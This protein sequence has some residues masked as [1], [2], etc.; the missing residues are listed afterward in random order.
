MN[1]QLLQSA[2]QASQ[3]GNHAETARICQEIRRSD[4]LNFLALF[5]EGFAHS[6]LGG[7]EEAERLMDE[8][9]K[10]NPQSAEAIYNRGCMLR[11]LGRHAEAL[12]CFERALTLK[13]DFLDAQINRGIA[14]LMVK[15]HGEA[16]AV[17]DKV[18]KSAPNEAEGWNNR[19][20]ALIELQRLEEALASL[21]RAISLRPDYDR[22]W[23]NRGITLYR[24]KRY[25]ESLVSL[26]RALAVNPH[27][28]AAINNRGN[29]LMA[30]KRFEEAA[31]AF[32]RAS[33]PLRGVGGA[34]TGD[35]GSID[36]LI[37]YGTALLT[38][39]RP[40]EAIAMYT[41]ALERQ[42]A[43]TEALC[44]RANA[45]VTQK[46]YEE[47]VKDCDAILKLEPEFK[48]MRGIAAHCRL[49]CCDWSELENDRAEIA[50]GLKAGKR[51]VPPLEIAAIASTAKEQSMAAR[52]VSADKHPPSAN[53]LWRGEIY[54]HKRIKLAYLSADFREHV[55]A[56][57]VAG[58]FEHHDRER[59]ETIALSFRGS[60]RSPMRRRVEAAFDRFVDVERKS[61]AELAQ[62]IREMEI[63]IAVDLM[64]YSGECRPGVL[65]FKPAPIQVNYL[66]YAGTMGAEYFDYVIADRT[67]V[68]EADEACYS[69]HVA[70]LPDTYLPYDAK[71]A[72]AP[73]TPTRAQAGLPPSGF[74]FASFNN[75]YKFRPESFDV[76]MRLLRSIEGSAIW[77]PA[78]NPA[79]MRNL[80]REAQAR[81]VDPARLVFA[82]FVPS[83]ADHLAR[84]SLADL[85]LDTFPFNAHTTAMDALVAG[86]P[87]LTFAGQSFAG[88]VAA[89]LNIAAGLPEMVTHSVNDYEF[90][91]FKLARDPAALR[92]I[93]TKLERNRSN[94]ALF[95]TASY[96]RNL[97]TAYATMHER[98]RRGDAPESFTVDSPSRH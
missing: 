5:L 64:G 19:A 44:N 84:L 79:A 29:T 16:L 66:G 42:P 46:R 85:F 86:V 71:R 2:W 95:D 80:E 12:Q 15:R 50:A 88:R 69:E 97:E 52:I 47:A 90:L 62:L 98:Y 73:A 24:L 25:E 91:A 70:R 33:A 35:G 92:A 6:M 27:L 1:D 4:P 53:P 57:I 31:Y 82:P 13:P 74:V 36:A 21:D 49:N 34:P 45:L 67:V 48:Y 18:V 54:G 17:F 65:A 68:P 26:D 14:L 20:N 81:G 11:N 9:A 51:V 76:W 30:L 72:P 43:N 83:P 8:A 93:R 75:S 56:N 63:D 96:T 28:S 10:V 32:D 55:V 77:L 78:S 22:A 58:V 87:L 94:S 61:D 59:F 3:A 89:S 60:D 41:M 37:N 40:D 23:N 7:Y 38:L 39:K